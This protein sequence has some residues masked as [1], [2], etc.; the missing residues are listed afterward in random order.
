MRTQKYRFR[1]LD[2]LIEEVHRLFDEGDFAESLSP[3]LDAQSVDLMKLAVHEWL[4]NLVQHARFETD[5]P[6]VQ[7]E[8][9]PNGT[10][11]ECVIEDNSSGFNFGSH[12]SARRS[13]L[14]AFPERGM[15]L[16]MLNA[17]TEGLSY[18]QIDENQNRL[19]FAVSAN[20]DPW[21]DVPF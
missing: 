10:M 9:R 3:V 15:G 7:F 17:C 6:S 12:L 4:A 16:L 19:E 5:Q 8:V 11:V 1:D 14:E 13:L 18:R 2:T 20:R 21:F